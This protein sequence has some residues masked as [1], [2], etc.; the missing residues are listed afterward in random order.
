M[1]ALSP[2]R[3]ET[4]P[5][6]LCDASREAVPLGNGNALPRV[7]AAEWGRCTMTFREMVKCPVGNSLLFSSCLCTAVRCPSQHAAMS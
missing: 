6:G 4:V 7:P 2:Q 5:D 1:P 3:G